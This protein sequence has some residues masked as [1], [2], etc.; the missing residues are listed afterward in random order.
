MAMSAYPDGM[1]A[2]GEMYRVLHPLG[3]LVL[4]DVNHPVKPTLAGRLIAWGWRAAGDVFRDMGGLLES[5]GFTSETSEIGG[6]GTVH[7][8]VA[9][10]SG[11]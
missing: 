4:I 5:T 7:L 2:I 1:A 11:T 6:Y 9:E 8:Y 10:K 3:R